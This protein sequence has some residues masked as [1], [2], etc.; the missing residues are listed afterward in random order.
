MNAT[1]TFNET[2]GRLASLP[3]QVMAFKDE[4]NRRQIKLEGEIEF[5]NGTVDLA[6]REVRYSDGE[7]SPLSGREVALLQ[8]L[9]DHPGRIISREELLLSV[10]RLNPQFVITRTVDMHIAKL[11]DKLRDNPQEPAILQTVR[12]RGYIWNADAARS[13]VAA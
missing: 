5:P 9:S 3:A 1:A 11:R 7:T 8:Y 13:C 2:F 12:G 10:W 6:Q 4:F